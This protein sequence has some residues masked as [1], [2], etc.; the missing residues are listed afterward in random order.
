M[1]VVDIARPNSLQTQRQRIYHIRIELYRQGTAGFIGPCEC[2]GKDSDVFV[3]IILYYRGT[4][5]IKRN[6][7]MLAKHAVSIRMFTS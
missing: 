5:H 6:K 4:E 2:L 3:F 7:E 1:L